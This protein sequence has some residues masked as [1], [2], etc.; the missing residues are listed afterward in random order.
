[1]GKSGYLALLLSTRRQPSLAQLH[2]VDNVECEFIAKKGKVQ[3]W[4]GMVITIYPDVECRADSGSK[5][6]DTTTKGASCLST[7]I[8]TQ[9]G[10]PP[11]PCHPPKIELTQFPAN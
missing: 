3:L 1:M 5:K 7:T 10:V 2:V 9:N 4:H 8:Q 11:S 6:V